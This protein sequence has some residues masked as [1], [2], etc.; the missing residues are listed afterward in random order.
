MKIDLYYG[1]EDTT[2]F[3][4]FAEGG[5]L[6]YIDPD[7][8]QV[9]HDRM[10]GRQFYESRSGLTGQ[11]YCHAR[12]EYVLAGRYRPDA[13][14]FPLRH[15]ETVRINQQPYHVWL[16]HVNSSEPDARGV[17]A[18]YPVVMVHADM[19]VYREYTTHSACDDTVLYPVILCHADS[20][21]HVIMN[22]PNAPAPEYR[23]DIPVLIDD[24]AGELQRVD[25]R[26]FV[27][28]SVAGHVELEIVDQPGIVGV[29]LVQLDNADWYTVRYG[30]PDH[31][32]DGVAT[33]L[34]DL[35][36]G[37]HVGGGY[38]TTGRA[39]EIVRVLPGGSRVSVAQLWAGTRFARTV[40]EVDN[41]QPREMSRMEFLKECVT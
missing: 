35:P 39:R 28:P 2:V 29:Q 23:H 6:E 25:I 3:I 41:Y 9:I 18:S 14:A 21:W 22:G 26:R 7:D 10:G 16:P 17:D 4:D 8:R 33:Y 12:L 31:R 19:S 34:N 38:V 30:W 5:Y 27:H 15:G 36:R 37:V 1:G 11:G 13:P 40:D 24:S 32:L 20:A